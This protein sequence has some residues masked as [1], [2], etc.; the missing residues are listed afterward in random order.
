MTE[1]P[2]GLSLLGLRTQRGVAPTAL[3]SEAFGEG[4]CPLRTLEHAFVCVCVCVCGDC[5]RRSV[6]Y[7][8]EC[9]V[10]FCSLPPLS[11]H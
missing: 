1:V 4:D 2:C 10:G 7:K 3:G 6:R 8:G 5:F 11:P 9:I